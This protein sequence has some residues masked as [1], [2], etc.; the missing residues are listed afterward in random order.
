MKYQS[1]EGSLIR[2]TRFA[3]NLA[4]LTV[5]KKPKHKP[6]LIMVHSYYILNHHRFMG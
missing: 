1:G 5:R 3:N 2:Y 6:D 4:L